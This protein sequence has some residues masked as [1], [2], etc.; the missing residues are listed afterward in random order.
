MSKTDFTFE[1]MKKWMNGEFRMSINEDMERN[2]RAISTRIDQTQAELRSHKEHVQKELDLMRKELGSRT[3]PPIVQPDPD[4]YAAAA[5]A[6][7]E[8]L[9]ADKV[10]G[11]SRETKH[12]LRSRRSSRFYPIEGTSEEELR[13][14]LRMFLEEKLRIPSGDIR[15]DD[16]E[17]IRRVR[18]GRDKKNM[19]EVT[20][21]F[22]DI[23][24]RDRINS[25]AR[26]LGLFVDPTGKPT[27]G[28]RFDIPDHLASVHRTLLQY[29]HAMWTKYKK[30]KDF[31][32][33]IRFDDVGRTF[34]L[35]IKFPGRE[36]WVS[37][38]YERALLDRKANK[39]AESEAGGD[40]LSTAGEAIVYVEEESMPSGTAGDG[41]SVT[42]TS[43][44]AP[45]GK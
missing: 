36:D 26:N 28:I 45:N 20:V 39:S 1:D 10:S 32:R 4:S 40:L 19:N 16:V 5:T 9:P 41:G 35:D 22:I 25:Y 8:C 11:D 3:N 23:D 37:V 18:V 14:N 29:P 2:N 12:F 27:A 43:W 15:E 34:C 38:S 33:N 17:S 6:A 30:S 7:K 21:L 44:R 31:K 42:V 24:T 13:T